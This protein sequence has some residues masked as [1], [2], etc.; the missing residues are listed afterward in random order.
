[1]TLSFI[2][3]LNL[4]PNPLGRTRNS[5]PIWDPSKFMSQSKLSN[6]EIIHN[7]KIRLTLRKELYLRIPTMT[8]MLLA[9]NLM[10]EITIKV[11]Q[12]GQTNMADKDISKFDKLKNLAL[13]SKFIPERKLA[14]ERSVETFNKLTKVE[15]S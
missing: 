13:S 7:L 4:K 14:F 6:L 8:N 15:Q 12:E 3:P 1:M 5:N 2:K 10:E 9:Y 11:F